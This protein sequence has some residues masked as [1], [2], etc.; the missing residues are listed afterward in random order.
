MKVVRFQRT[1]LLDVSLRPKVAVLVAWLLVLVASAAAVGVLWQQ[2]SVQAQASPAS[3]S[4]AV[5]DT[6]LPGYI[7]GDSPRWVDINDAGHMVPGALRAQLYKDGQLHD[8]GTLPGD[9]LARALGINNTG[10]V[11]GYSEGIFFCTGQKEWWDILGDSPCDPHRRAFL[12]KEGQGMIDLGTLPG[13][14][15]SEATE[16][17]DAGQVVGK[18]Q[19]SEESGRHPWR[20]FLYEEGQGMTNLGTLGG[21]SSA[22]F[23]INNAGQVVGEALTAS[24]TKHAFLYEDGQMEDLGTLGGSLSI[25]HGINKFGEVVGHS[26]TTN[27]PTSNSLEMH[28]FLYKNGE[29]TDLGTLGYPLSTAFD[30]NDAGQVVGF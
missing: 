27:V 11:V 29:M 9:Q 3:P 19:V 12:Y 16:I 30:I 24:G 14:N 18:S 5:T 6:G 25:A 22:A 8:L 21:P 17:N 1:D 28:A 13:G 10:E 7:W 23:D 2:Q 15:Y 20:A 4:Y 26:M